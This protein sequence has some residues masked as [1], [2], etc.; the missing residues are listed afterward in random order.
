MINLLDVGY[1]IVSV[2]LSVREHKL[3]IID[4]HPAQFRS[5][6]NIGCTNAVIS[7]K[8]ILQSRKEHGADSCTMFIDLVKA[9]D[10]TRH[11]VKSVALNKMGKPPKHI[12]RVGKLRDRFSAV[13]KH[14]KEEISIRHG[15]GMK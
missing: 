1:K 5:T 3:L 8:I 15:Y 10:S 6:P 9:H 7:L 13:L 11:D 2:V 4:G 12:Q 14:I